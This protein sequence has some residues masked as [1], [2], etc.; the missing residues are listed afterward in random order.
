MG[1]A[2]NEPEE[3]LGGSVLLGLELVSAEILDV[4]GLGGGSE[5]TFTEFLAY[6]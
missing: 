1:D 6:N 4:F 3:T 5:L 2:P